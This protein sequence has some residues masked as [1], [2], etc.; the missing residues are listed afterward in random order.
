MVPSNYSCV[1]PQRLLIAGHSTDA[2]VPP[3]DAIEQVIQLAERER[4]D[5]AD[6]RTKLEREQ[7]DV[8]NASHGWS[9]PSRTG[10]T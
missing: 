9:R 10:V 7:K 3:P 6:Q 4:D 5:I 1:T 2:A 8:A